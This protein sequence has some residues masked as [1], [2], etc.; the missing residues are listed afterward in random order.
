MLEG[1][2]VTIKSIKSCRSTRKKRWSTVGFA[3][4]HIFIYKYIY[5]YTYVH[6]I[7]TYVPMAPNWMS[8]TFVFIWQGGL[9]LVDWRG[10]ENLSISTCELFFKERKKIP[11]GWGMGIIRLSKDYMAFEGIQKNITE[12]IRKLKCLIVTMQLSTEGNVSKHCING[13]HEF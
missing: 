10:R 3:M 4:V 6:Y 8:H 2:F 13:T 1:F 12:S 5:I 11:A 9:F 7:K